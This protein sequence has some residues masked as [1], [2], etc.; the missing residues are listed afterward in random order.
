MT[1]CPD[2]GSPL[3]YTVADD[4]EDSEYRHILEIC[5]HCGY[6]KTFVDY[7]DEN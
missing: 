1:D 2:C 5:A 6:I 7:L 3:G 4:R